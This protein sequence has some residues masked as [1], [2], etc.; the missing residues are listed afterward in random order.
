VKVDKDLLAKM[1]V[2]SPRAAALYEYSG[3]LGPWT[4]QE[5]AAVFGFETIVP[6][7]EPRPDP[8]AEVVAADAAL[9]AARLAYE[10]ASNAWK[11][12]ILAQR[13]HF[14]RGGKFIVV[15][16]YGPEPTDRKGKA[17]EAAIDRALEARG[18]A[19]TVMRSAR[20]DATRLR[21]RWQATL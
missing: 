16:G 5:Y 18:D 7:P 12:A 20:R 15:Q 9:D 2:T 10:A 14:D 6:E 4:Y 19:E 11:T 1:K 13:R 17:M 8:P 3:C 21:T